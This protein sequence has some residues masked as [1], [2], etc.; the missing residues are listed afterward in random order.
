[1]SGLDVV[2][3]AFTA[4]QICGKLAR[5]LSILIKEVHGATDAARKS[6]VVRLSA[7]DHGLM[8]VSQVKP[9]LPSILCIHAL[10]K[11]SSF[12][13]QLQLKM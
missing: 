13:R 3:V 5:E 2:S 8:T 10:R 12:S 7:C 6:R 1:M 4:T 9:K 11:S